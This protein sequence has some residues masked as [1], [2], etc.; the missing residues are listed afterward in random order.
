MSPELP[1][2]LLP[3]FQVSVLSNRIGLFL[4]FFIPPYVIETD[5]SIMDSMMIQ[6]FYDLYLV[7][8][9]LCSLALVL[10]LFGK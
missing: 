1:A 7:V 8:G 6:H 10:S 9:F 4:G 2:T 3:S 5:P